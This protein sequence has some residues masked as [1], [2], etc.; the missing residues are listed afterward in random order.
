[1][2]CGLSPLDVARAEAEAIDNCYD[3]GQVPDNRSL[4]LR[5][6]GD[7]RTWAGSR[8]INMAVGRWKKRGGG[9]AWAYTHSWR[10]VHRDTWDNVSILASVSNVK[11]AAEAAKNGYASAIIV[12]EHKSEK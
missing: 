11:E 3:G 4:R 6:A 5:V 1:E 8:I 10:H 7:S 12:S 9:N 2:S